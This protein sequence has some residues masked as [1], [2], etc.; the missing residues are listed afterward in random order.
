[1]TSL[2]TTNFKWRRGNGEFISPSEMRTGHL[3]NTVV[4]IWNHSAPI[5]W[6]TYN[7]RRYVF[8]EFYTYQYMKQAV[9]HMLPELLRRPDLTPFQIQTLQRMASF[10]EH[11]PTKLGT[12]RYELTHQPSRPHN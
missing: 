10:M 1:M 5:A 6:Q 11:D 2:T 7:H 3:F 4:M 12:V 9:A 8:P